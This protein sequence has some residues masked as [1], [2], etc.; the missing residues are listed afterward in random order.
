LSIS[1]VDINSNGD[2]DE[3]WKYLD[4]VTIDVDVENLNNDD[5]IEN[6]QVE[7]ALFDSQGKNAIKD[8]DFSNKDEEKIDLGDIGDGN[9]ET[10]TFEFKVPADVNSGNYKL[11]IKAYSKKSGESSECT[12][13]SSDFDNTLYQKIEVKK[14]DDSGKFIAFD[15]IRLNP[16]EATCGDRVTLDTDVWNVGEDDEDQVKVNLRSSELKVDDFYEIRSDLNQGDKDKASFSF[17]VPEGLTDKVYSLLLSSEYDYRNGEYRDQ[18]DDDTKVGLKI[19]GCSGSSGG[20]GG[21]GGTTGSAVRISAS[22]DSDA[23][24]GQ[25]LKVT[26]TIRNS[27]TSTGTFIVGASGYEDWASLNKLSQRILTLDAGESQDVT[28]TFDV[29]GDASGEQSFTVEVQAGDKV[30]TREVAV[31]IGSG[32]G[33]GVGSLFQGNSLIWVIGIINVIL[34]IL[35]IVV[36]ARVAR[37]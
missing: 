10:A 20:N 34:I 27:G 5:S 26:A 35:I 15:N 6:V 28:F 19:V 32:S 31:N 14:E 1:N 9:E 29:D 23:V 30:E 17:D 22:L 8:L 18:S 3:E 2:K 4:Q 13:T 36:A 33:A 12:D 16:I 21:T 37:R 24:A 7:L 25:P 11:A